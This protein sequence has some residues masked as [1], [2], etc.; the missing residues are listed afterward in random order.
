[1]EIKIQKLHPEAKIPTYGHPGDAG[2]DLYAVEEIAVAPGERKGIGAGIAVAIPH[3][4]VGLVWDKSG[5]AFKAG[6]TTMAGVIDATYRGEIRIALYNSGSETKTFAVGDKVAQI[7]IQPVS[8]ASFVEGDLDET[9]R[10][11]DGFGSTGSS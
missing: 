2:M 4:Y 10:G 9:S 3:G 7:L 8:Q 6:I 5:L 1:M 11:A